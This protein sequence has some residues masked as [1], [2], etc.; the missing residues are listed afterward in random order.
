MRLRSNCCVSHFGWKIQ[1]RSVQESKLTAKMLG[2]CLFQDRWLKDN[3]CQ[4]WVLKDKLDEHYTHGA[5][6]EIQFFVLFLTVVICKCN[7]GPY[8]VFIWL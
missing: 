1:N 2:K 8:K 3:A 4:E 5:A 7:I 6:C